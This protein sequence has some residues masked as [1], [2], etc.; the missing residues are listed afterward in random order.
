MGNP[1]QKIRALSL[2]ALFLISCEERSS[3]T[4][5]GESS[6]LEPEI[7]KLALPSCEVS[8]G[9]KLFT[10][11]SLEKS[12]VDFKNLLIGDHEM[13]R[14]YY[15]GFSCGSVAMAD[16]NGDGR[17]DLFFTGGAGKNGLF[18]QKEESLTFEDAT[19]SAGVSGGDSWSAGSVA[20]DID[21]DGDVD[22]LVCNYDEAPHLF[23]NDGKAVFVESGKE[24]GISQVDAYLM[25]SV[26]DYDR[27]G[28]LDV[29]LVSNQYYREGGRPAKPPYEKG[30][31]GRLRVKEEF[32]K[33]YRLKP[34]GQGGFQM[35]SAGRPDLLLRND[36][37]GS[38]A[39]KFVDV[40]SEAGITEAGFGLSATWWDFNKDGW[41]D[42]H[43]GN[44][45]SDPDRLYHNLGNGKFVDVANAALPHSAWFS[46]GAD[47]ADVNGDGWDDLFCADMAF[48]THYKQ[49]VGMGQMGAK[50]AVLESI[51]PL[52]VMRNHLFINT[53]MGPFQEVAQMA[54]VAKSDW[55]WG[56]KFEDFDL[57][58][59]KDLFV[60]NG[61]IRSFN[62]SDHSAAKGSQI[63]KTL[64]DLWKNTEPRPEAN[65][66]F[67]NAGNLKFKNVAKDWGLDDT[68]VSHGLACGDLDGDGD[69]D[70]V[71]TNNDGLTSIYR[72][73]CEGDL[74]KVSLSG[75]GKKL[76]GSRCQSGA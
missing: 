70:I 43:V 74:I 58:G 32:A 69:V 34:N 14:L 11:V 7:K 48:T 57:D 73:D 47:V 75:T 24:C 61:A 42:L 55:T 50:Q 64:W 52:Q 9:E 44:D 41:P 49:K 59:R 12:G 37:Q 51:S 56:V 35:D 45:F 2:A 54:G 3:V 22:L 72:N 68:G 20:V 36:S 60:A 13:S 8:A 31:D 4:A 26:C 67:R 66:A 65:L 25:P 39:P 10:K 30:A 63:G 40:T 53:G 5:G 16:F 23:L 21:G 18:L 46:M 62:H 28:D 17:Q 6:S 38:G 27:D 19:E 71:V 15:S 76:P 1:F 29:F 33:Y